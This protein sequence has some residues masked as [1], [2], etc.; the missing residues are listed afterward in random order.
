M[1]MGS[2]VDPPSHVVF[3]GADQ[4]LSVSSDLRAAGYSTM[5]VL[6]KRQADFQRYT[7]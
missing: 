3:Y 7:P 4:V 6:V 2:G 5:R 1:S